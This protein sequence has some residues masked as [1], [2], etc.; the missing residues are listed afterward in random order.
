MKLR[1]NLFYITISSVMI[2]IIITFIHFDVL[3]IIKKLL[4]FVSN[5]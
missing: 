3:N 5:L 4:N 2:F 1:M